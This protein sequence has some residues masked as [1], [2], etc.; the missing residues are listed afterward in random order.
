MN[1]MKEKPKEFLKRIKQANSSTNI[2]NSNRNIF[3]ILIT[4]K[5][6]E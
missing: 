6:N 3:Y 5:F 1:S 2:N 4:I